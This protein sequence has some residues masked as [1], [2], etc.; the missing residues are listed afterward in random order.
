[1]NNVILMGRLTSDPKIN[2]TGGQSPTCVAK[3]TVAVARRMNPQESDF[4]SCTAFGKTAEFFDRYCHKGIKL[5]I[6]G[7]IQ[8]GSYDGRDG[9]KHYTTDVIVENAE[10]CES[11]G[12]SQQNTQYQVPQ[13]QQAPAQY[14]QPQQPQQ[15]QAPPTAAPQQQYNPQPQTAVP[16][17]QYQQTPPPQ[18]QQQTFQTPPAAQAAQEG[19]MVIPDELQDEGLPFN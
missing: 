17:Q 14:Q 1:M 7:R 3:F 10:F 11:K 2:Y 18:Y 4:I 8:T 19:F 13:Y 5:C 15:Y 9:V 16:P 6:E 12:V